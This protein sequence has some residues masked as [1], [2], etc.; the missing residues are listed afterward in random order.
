MILLRN[1]IEIKLHKEKMT[2]LFAFEK[3][4]Y[5]LEISQAEEEKMM[6]KNYRSDGEIGDDIYEEI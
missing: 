4:V 6:I 1:L 3:F 5:N 2:Q